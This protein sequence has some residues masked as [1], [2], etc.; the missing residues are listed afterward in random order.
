MRQLLQHGDSRQIQR[1]TRICLESTNP[2]FTKNHSFIAAG[3]NIF[4]TH[5][6]FFHGVGQ[7]ALQQNY[8]ISTSQ[9]FQQIKVL[10]ITRPYLNDIHLFIQ[11]QV[12]NIHNL[13]N[14][15]HAGFFLGFQKQFDAFSFQP[16]E[17]IRRSAWFEC[18]TAQQIGSGRLDSLR[19][20]QNLVMRFYRA[21]AC[22]KLEVSASDFM[23]CNINYRI[24]RMELAVR[25]LKRIRNAF[26]RFNDFQSVQKINIYLAGI[27][28][29][30]NDRLKLSFRNMDIQ[31]SAAKPCD[32][33]LYLLFGYT[34]F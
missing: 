2:S 27:A 30:A 16:L 31:P 13:G 6:Q 33:I 9:F 23:A 32:Q 19:H 15:G 34:L 3:H 7:T 4:R 14:D 21:R 1:I 22:N 29:Q 8:L 17:I 18:A 24:I 26:Y 11:I 20:F 25:T 5:Q 12:I 10:H 28:D